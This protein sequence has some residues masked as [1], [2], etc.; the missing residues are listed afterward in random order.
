M[1]KVWKQSR[2]G[3]CV[4]VTKGHG[5]RKGSVNPLRSVLQLTPLLNHT[6][7][8]TSK[9]PEQIQYKF[10]KFL[11]KSDTSFVKLKNLLLISFQEERR[12]QN[13]TLFQ[14]EK[15]VL[16]HQKMNRYA[17]G[18]KSPFCSYRERLLRR[19]VSQ[20][21][22]AASLLVISLSSSEQCTD[23]CC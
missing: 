18:R 4:L 5:I 2:W 20:V 15:C 1:G 13:E 23:S 10:T 9:S 3:F 17:G 8:P 14:C 19:V 11:K 21:K 6:F 16:N 12:Q 22:G 7:L